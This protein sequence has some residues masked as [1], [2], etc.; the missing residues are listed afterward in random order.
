MRAIL[1]IM[2]LAVFG[3]FLISRSTI[4]VDVKPLETTFSHLR[5]VFNNDS[6]II[7]NDVKFI[8]NK[9]HLTQVANFLLKGPIEAVHLVSVGVDDVLHPIRTA[10]DIASSIVSEGENIASSIVSEG[11]HLTA[12]MI[13]GAVEMPLMVLSEAEQILSKNG[14]VHF[15]LPSINVTELTSLSLGAFSRLINNDVVQAVLKDTN[16][17]QYVNFTVPLLKCHSQI[18]GKYNWNCCEKDENTTECCVF[19]PPKCNFTKPVL[20]VLSPGSIWFPSTWFNFLLP[21]PVETI[22]PS[23]ILPLDILKYAPNTAGLS[24][25]NGHITWVNRANCVPGELCILPLYINYLCASCSV[26]HKCVTSS[27]DLLNEKLTNAVAG[28]DIQCHDNSL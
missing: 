16:V 9:T 28:L 22:L 7:I 6:K 17:L 3:Y 20:P 8:A 14:V 27:N 13:V 25:P 5:D 24:C 10:K 26:E 23:N 15:N 12:E 4:K 2:L 19:L 11:E 21:R 1:I 18:V